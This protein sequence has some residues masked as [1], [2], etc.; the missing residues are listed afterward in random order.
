MGD[1]RRDRP[2]PPISFI[3]VPDMTSSP[4][5]SRI[6]P[7]GV[8][9]T[10]RPAADDVA[11]EMVVV[12]STNRQRAQR[13]LL[14][15]GELRQCGAMGFMT[16]IARIAV[17]RFVSVLVMLRSSPAEDLSEPITVER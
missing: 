1:G 11:S 10:S 13:Q 12:S 8:L 16:A 6:D 9:G 7:K 14:G 3:G 4:T 15:S 17:D 2:R 5:S